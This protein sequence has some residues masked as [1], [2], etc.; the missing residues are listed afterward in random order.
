MLLLL[1]IIT[2]FINSIILNRDQVIPICKFIGNFCPS[3]KAEDRLYKIAK[4]KRNRGERQIEFTSATTLGINTPT[5]WNSTLKML[6]NLAQMNCL[7]QKLEVIAEHKKIAVPSPK[8][9]L[10]KDSGLL[11]LPRSIFILC[12]KELQK[13]C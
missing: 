13:T 9:F 4:V 7:I 10:A 6:I 11:F 12:L 1:F 5:S 8:C 3:V 2:I